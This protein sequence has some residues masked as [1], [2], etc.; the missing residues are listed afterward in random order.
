MKGLHRRDR[1]P[2][3]SPCEFV[4]LRIKLSK[5]LQKIFLISLNFCAENLSE[6]KP[7]ALCNV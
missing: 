3:I 5:D 4:S 2:L 7:F 1:Q 6:N